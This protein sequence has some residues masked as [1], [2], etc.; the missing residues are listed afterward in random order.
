MLIVYL[1]GNSGMLIK[2]TYEDMHIGVY[3]D[4]SA[5]VCGQELISID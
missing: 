2:Y 5:V 1:Y 3:V 4:M